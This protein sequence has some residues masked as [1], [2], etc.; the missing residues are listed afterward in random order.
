M[1]SYSPVAACREDLIMRTYVVWA[2]L[3]S[4]GAWFSG[5]N[6]DPPV[7]RNFLAQKMTGAQEVPPRV[8]D[9]H[10][11]AVF[12]LS[13]DGAQLRYQLTVTRINNV[14]GAHIHTGAAGV[15]G[16]IIFGIY[17]APPGGGAH[18]GKLA[19]GTIVRGVTALPSALGAAL[20]NAQRFDELIRLMRTGD[21]YVNVHTNDGVAPTNTGA[22][23]F[24]GGEIRGQ[25]RS[26]R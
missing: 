17:D 23:D 25:F 13:P 15:N 24:P 12:N 5:A 3:V 4:L 7:A 6:A 9:A 1:E 8:T 26:R 14:V 22:G 21:T 20:T 19:Q 18:N 16:G 10:G 2:C 11:V